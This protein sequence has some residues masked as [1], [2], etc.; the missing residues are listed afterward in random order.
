MTY[1][2]KIKINSQSN[3]MI[4]NSIDV[5]ENHFKPT[6]EIYKGISWLNMIN[7][8]NVFIK[9]IVSQTGK[10]YKTIKKEFKKYET[11][12]LKYKANVHCISPLKECYN[13]IRKEI[14]IKCNIV[15]KV[16]GKL[17]PY[18]LFSHLPVHTLKDFIKNT[19]CS[20]FEILHDDNKR[21]VYFDFD[22]YSE[23]KIE[24]IKQSIEYNT[25]IN[26][27]NIDFKNPKICSSG[28]CGY[29]T[30][31]KKYKLSIHII[32]TD[33]HFNN[34]HHQRNSNIK[35]YAKSIGSDEAVY[36]SN[37]C[38]KF[39]LQSKLYSDRVQLIIEDE[40]IENH[41]IQNVNSDSIECDKCIIENIY[42]NNNIK[43]K[44]KIIFKSK[45][46]SFKSKYTNIN[47]VAPMV[48]KFHT[49]YLNILKHIPLLPIS[50]GNNLKYSDMFRL[51]KESSI[52][53]NGF[54][55]IWKF[56]K[57]RP[58]QNIEHNEKYWENIYN[59]SLK[60]YSTYSKKK[61]ETAK[62]FSKINI[63][64]LLQQFYGN[65]QNPYLRKF[66]KQQIDTILD[67]DMFN[68]IINT[69]YLNFS[70]ISNISEKC[71]IIKTNMGSGKTNNINLL[72]RS[73]YKNNSC[74]SITN[75]VSLAVNQYGEFNRELTQDEINRIKLN[76][77]G[78]I[79]LTNDFKYYKDKSTNIGHEN[80]ICEIESIGKTSIRDSYDVCILDEC[81]SLLLSFADETCHKGLGYSN[82]WKKFI[83]IISSC[84]KLII[85]DAF[86]SS[87]TIDFIKSLNIDYY[88]IGRKND[89]I[90]KTISDYKCFDKYLNNLK[91]DILNDKK[92]CIQYPYKSAKCS[93]FK[94]HIEQISEML[95]KECNLTADDIMTYHGDTNDFDKKQLKNVDDIWENKKVIIY[96]S[97][98]TVGVNCNIKCDKLYMM[99]SNHCLPRDTIQ[100]SMRFRDIKNTNIEMFIF[101]NPLDN[102]NIYQPEVFKIPQLDDNNFDGDF[103]KNI[104][105]SLMKNIIIEIKSKSSDT[106]KY[107]CEM[108][109]YKITKTIKSDSNKKI[110][111]KEIKNKWIP[112][113]NNSIYEY[114][115]IELINSKQVTDLIE[116]QNS[117]K[118]HFINNETGENCQLTSMQ[119]KLQIQ[120]YVVNKFLI[121]KKDDEE[122]MIYKEKF[123]KD[124]FKKPYLL[125][126]LND[127]IINNKCIDKVICKNLG[128]GEYE[129]NTNPLSVQDKIDIEKHYELGKGFKKKTD[130]IIRKLILKCHFKAD[131]VEVKRK[132]LIFK[133][134]IYEK[135]I[136]PISKFLNKSQ[137][138][139]DLSEYS[140][141]EDE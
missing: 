137:F 116:L 93:Y 49:S 80:V 14:R 99:Y 105:D 86:I 110:S 121:N 118:F 69:Q 12:F 6:E 42:N 113:S 57:N 123:N 75:R 62:Y 41:I 94:L 26:K 13:D 72:L 33:R 24:N 9:N 73:I 104:H 74:I 77:N 43:S 3:N 37:Q 100:G 87:K 103:Y 91:N 140:F 11:K 115:N 133:K 102:Q 89:L 79:K 83:D 139:I 107:F 101:K 117:G 23:S 40:N 66:K 96:N 81:E 127:I 44:K 90:H 10:D 112:D 28:S 131:I 38:F 56:L 59:S 32:L 54:S 48:H 34:I 15:K 39:P 134:D 85:M 55:R 16:K 70:D 5:V 141:I 71:T 29:D 17:F 61:L 119:K 58:C 130:N 82:N 63:F 76:Y 111:I 21:K 35:Q 30:K 95:I 98:I 132:I 109:G 4:L 27:I 136:E 67:K 31:Q 125:G 53:K 45:K 106:L 7:I 84:E 52:E 22:M 126:G 8:K 120:K 122:Y 60:L 108:T 135:Y 1:K 19:N 68:K 18:V 88:L 65:I 64:E 92:V 20:L 47:R 78:D 97:A 138:Q 124:L 46:I 129:L 36:C 114:E 2:T 25:I 50:S 128:T 51:V